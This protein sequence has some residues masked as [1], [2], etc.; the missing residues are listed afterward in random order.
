M[1]KKNKYRLIVGLGNP[2]AQY[3]PTY[4]NVGHL[5]I[6]FLMKTAAGTM[7]LIKKG[8]QKNFEYF[9]FIN[10]DSLIFMKPLTFMNE[11]GGAVAACLKYFRTKP[12]E[13][14]IIHDDS[15]IELG[16]SKLSFGRGAG[17]HH[18][19]ESIINNLKTRNFWRLRIG[20]RKKEKKG[21]KRRKAGEMVLR[22]IT[23][24]DNLILEKVIKESKI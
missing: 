6:N 5:A 4:H 16:E 7:T 10:G 20:I 9:K 19:I 11:S 3:A 2:A 13:T 8:K 24:A 17:G 1:D 23:A 14:L 15:D 21:S 18:G 22:K 12:E